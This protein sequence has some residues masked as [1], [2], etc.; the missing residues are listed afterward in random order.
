MSACVRARASDRAIER[1]GNRPPG[2]ARDLRT[3]DRLAVSTPTANRR[4]KGDKSAPFTSQTISIFK[5]PDG[6]RDT[7][8]SGRETK[9][10]IEIVEFEEFVVPVLSQR[11]SGS[12]YRRGPD[13]RLLLV[14]PEEGLVVDGVVG[15]IE[16]LFCVLQLG[17]AAVDRGRGG[18]KGCRGRRRVFHAWKRGHGEAGG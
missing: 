6:D 3:V 16:F 8:K 9:V 1:V 18:R 13:I 2:K 14:I 15:H 17:R 12:T 7:A 5:R 11:L 4:G 10:V